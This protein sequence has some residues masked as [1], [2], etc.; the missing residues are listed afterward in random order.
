MDVLYTVSCCQQGMVRP[1]LEKINLISRFSLTD[2][3][4]TYNFEMNLQMFL[5]GEVGRSA[6]VAQGLRQISEKDS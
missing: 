4:R 2:N 6:R 3:N 5:C 1:F